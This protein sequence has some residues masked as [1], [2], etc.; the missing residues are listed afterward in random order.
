M[1]TVLKR[2]RNSKYM[3]LI[4]QKSVCDVQTKAMNRQYTN[5]YNF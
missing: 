4:S 1:P 2:K 5:N 3:I